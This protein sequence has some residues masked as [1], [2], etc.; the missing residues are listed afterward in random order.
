MREYLNER[1][2]SYAQAEVTCGFKR[3]FL[4]SGGIVGSDKLA[5]FAQA[6]PDSDMY[7]IVTGNRGDPRLETARRLIDELK[8]KSSELAKNLKAL[9]VLVT[10]MV[11]KKQNDL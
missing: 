3:G 1:K 7:Y 4:S 11:T 6:Y 8:T 9:D 10:N 5:M 2:I